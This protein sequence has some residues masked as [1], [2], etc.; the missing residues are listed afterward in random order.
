[1][2]T[3]A[4]KIAA[5]ADLPALSSKSSKQSPVPQV[6]ASKITK[7]FLDAIYAFLDGLVLLGSEESPVLERPSSNMEVIPPAEG[8][9]EMSLQELVDLKDGVSLISCHLLLCK[10]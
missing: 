4:Y 10:H 2:T 5:G 7:A 6:F 8:A 3:V 1:M 9:V